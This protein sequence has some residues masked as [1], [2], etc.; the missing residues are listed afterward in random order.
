M[1]SLKDDAT[2]MKVVQKRLIN[3]VGQRQY[4]AHTK[5]HF[6]LPKFRASRDFVILSLDR[7]RKVDT[8]F[9]KDKAVTLDF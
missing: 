8:K 4:S 1:K 2:P 7:S 6:Q 9:D 5:N 3:S